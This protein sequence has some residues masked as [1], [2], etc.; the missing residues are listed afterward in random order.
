VDFLIPGRRGHQSKI[1]RSD[2]FKGCSRD[3]NRHQ[4]LYLI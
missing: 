4:S 2:R 3:L 1:V